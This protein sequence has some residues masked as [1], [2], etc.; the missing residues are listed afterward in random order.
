MD[1]FNKQDLQKIGKHLLAKKQ[2][3]AVAESVTSGLLQYAFANI[4]DAAGF[5]QGG[6]TAYNIAQKFRHLKVE[7]IHASAVNCVSEK[8]ARE[9]ALN[10]CNAFGSH[11]GIGITGYATATPEA[12]G[13]IFAFYAITGAGKLKAAGRLKPPGTEPSAI[14][15][16]YANAVLHKLAQ[17]L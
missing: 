11:W 1:I 7:P 12:G 10:V 5:Y 16:Y 15:L 2:T 9:M 4:P 6:L 13:K 3:I 8:V 17:L 14:Q